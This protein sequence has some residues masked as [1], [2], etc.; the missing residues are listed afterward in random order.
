[1]KYLG[2]AFSV[3]FIGCSSF[4]RE[5][6]PIARVNGS[7][8]TV[9]DFKELINTLKPKDLDTTGQEHSEMRNL[10][11]KTLVRRQVILTEANRK[12][13]QVSDSD[14]EGG[15]QKYKAG[16]TVGAF[17]QS[18][19]DQ[20]LDEA[21]WKE[22]VKET[23]LIEKMFEDSKPQIPAPGREEALDFYQRNRG[24]FV[25]EASAKALQ[26]VVRDEDLAKE[27]R[28]KILKSPA[29]FAQLAKENSIGPEAQLNAMITIEKD[30]LTPE[31]DRALF[32]GK[33]NEISKVIQSPYGFHIFKVISRS[34]SLNLDFD[35]VQDQIRDRLIQ[36]RR[37]EWISKFEEGLIRSA[38][39]EYN[40]QLIQKL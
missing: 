21:T 34:P 8:I 5:S 28:K 29:S 10:V 18:L 16:Y 3:L 37:R 7:A 33:M 38:K 20:M 4:L 24:L 32:E 11:L 15:L 6:E 39:I 27:L 35:R 19:I 9:G 2:I 40:R 25:R 1:M 26:I 13:I 31:I 36:E 30:T 17:E 14:L 22:R 23:L 12:K